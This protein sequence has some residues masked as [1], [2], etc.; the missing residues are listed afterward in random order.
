MT[1]SP[2]PTTGDNNQAITVACGGQEPI[3]YTKSY[4]LDA[5]TVLA[6]VLRGHVLKHDSTRNFVHAA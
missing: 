1:S 2:V 6:G 5:T 3:D 4:E